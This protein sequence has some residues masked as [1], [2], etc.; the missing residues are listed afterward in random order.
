M[1][2]N[3]NDFRRMVKS[4]T[5]A[6]DYVAYDSQ[7][8]VKNSYAEENRHQVN[9]MFYPDFEQDGKENYIKKLLEKYGL[10]EYY[11]ESDFNEYIEAKHKEK[12]QAS[13]ETDPDNTKTKVYITPEEENELFNKKGR[14]NVLATQKSQSKS[15]RYYNLWYSNF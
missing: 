4:G 12:L 3:Y 10:R 1:M 9:S 15:K 7:K 2:Y 8:T 13:S 5:S 11:D 6:E 14:K